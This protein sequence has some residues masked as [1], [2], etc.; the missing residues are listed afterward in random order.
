VDAKVERGVRRGGWGAHGGTFGLV[1]E[2]IAKL[3]YFIPHQSFQ[4]QH[5]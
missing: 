4:G 5:D 1:P 3:E 2:G